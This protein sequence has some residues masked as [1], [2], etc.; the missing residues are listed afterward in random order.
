MP[1]ETKGISCFAFGVTTVFQVEYTVIS[2]F[3]LKVRWIL[4]GVRSISVLN[5]DMGPRWSCCFGPFLGLWVGVGPIGGLA[6]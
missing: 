1:E 3:E 4:S 5:L 6:C 2:H